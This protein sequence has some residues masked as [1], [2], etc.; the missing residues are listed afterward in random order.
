[1]SAPK[2]TKVGSLRK[3]KTP[4]KDNYIVIDKGVN[5]S[6]KEGMI[7]QVQDPRKK[8]DSSV[9]AGRITAEKADEIRAKIPEYIL[10]E[11]VLAPSK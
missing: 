6:L 9:A 3:S 8:L 10:R 1:M 2:W 7:L 11:I 4:G 5:V